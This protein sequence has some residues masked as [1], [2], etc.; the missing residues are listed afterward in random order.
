MFGRW[1]ENLAHKKMDD[2]Y[3]L[4]NSRFRYGVRLAWMD[5]LELSG[6]QVVI[7]FNDGKVH[8]INFGSRKEAH[9]AFNE[10]CRV[11]DKYL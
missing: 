4:G 11:W 10:L 7:T 8:E 2:F 5:W 3:Y 1:L 9:M 6:N